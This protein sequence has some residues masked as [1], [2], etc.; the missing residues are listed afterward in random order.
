MIKYKRNINFIPFVPPP[1]FPKL[2]VPTYLGPFLSERLPVPAHEKRT[3][4]IQLLKFIQILITFLAAFLTLMMVS[5]LMLRPVLKDVRMEAKTE[6]AAFARAL[7]ERNSLIPGLIES[8][9]GFEPGHTKLVERLVQA[10]SI[11]MRST[12]PDR[13]VAAV[14]EIDGTL[15]QVRKLGQSKPGLA[16]YPPF[17]SQWQKVEKISLRISQHRAQYNST[18]SSYNRLLT[19]FPQNLLAAAFGF[20]PLNIYPAI[21]LTGNQIQ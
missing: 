18:A 9:K 6:W 8:F 15:E 5:F 1:E 3:A 17:T 16:Q 2:A 19:V 7:P 10:R 12:D 11:S 14:D 20:V 13:I 4:S 21:G